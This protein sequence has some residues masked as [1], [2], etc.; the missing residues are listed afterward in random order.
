VEIE[1]DCANMMFASD[2]AQVQDQAVLTSSGDVTI[3]AG[4]DVLASLMITP[5]N[6][7]SRISHV[8][9]PS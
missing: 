3:G 2:E 6:T 1:S 7:Q 8:D 9:T 5:D 4:W